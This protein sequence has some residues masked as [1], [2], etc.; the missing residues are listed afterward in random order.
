MLFCRIKRRVVEL[1]HHACDD[2][3]VRH[4]IIGGRT[5]QVWPS[6]VVVAI[7]VDLSDISPWNLAEDPRFRYARRAFWNGQTI[8]EIRPMPVAAECYIPDVQNDRQPSMVEVI[9]LEDQPTADPAQWLFVD[10][11]VFRV[12]KR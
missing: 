3:F 5:E 10:L 7:R 6:V 9:R 2:P 8:V 11:W 4:P 1:A 12:F